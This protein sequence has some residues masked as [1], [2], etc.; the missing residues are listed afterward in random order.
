MGALYLGYDAVRSLDLRRLQRETGHPL[1]RPMSAQSMPVDT[2]GAL[3]DFAIPSTT[4]GNRH[5]HGTDIEADWVG[6]RTISYRS[7]KKA[8]F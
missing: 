7:I 4:H 8:P 2:L 5:P 3:F 1:L 6:P